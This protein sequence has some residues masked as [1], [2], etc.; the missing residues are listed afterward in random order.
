MEFTAGFSTD[1]ESSA[2]RDSEFAAKPATFD[3]GFV[4]QSLSS[5]CRNLID[6]Y[7]E[8]HGYGS[9]PDM[10]WKARHAKLIE[11]HREFRQLLRR[12]STTRSAKRSNESFVRIATA[13]LSLE[14][15]ASGFAGWSVLYPDAA[16]KAG[17]ILRRYARSP[18]MPLMDSYLYPPKI[19][20]L[21]AIA[22][23]A[24]PPNRLSD[25]AQGY[26]APIPRL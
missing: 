4:P 26:Q 7:H 15:L 24:P 10:L 20:G 23:L 22:A 8:L 9:L 16:A 1:D 2:D 19:G 17:A 18:H 14:I 25:A 5:Q 21:A 13:I 12:A 3:F 11:G 6:A